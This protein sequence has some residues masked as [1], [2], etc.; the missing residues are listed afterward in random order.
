MNTARACEVNGHVLE[1]QALHPKH[2]RHAARIDL[3][4]QEVVVLAPSITAVSGQGVADSGQPA[5]SKTQL[6]A[7]LGEVVVEVLLVL[8]AHPS[9]LA[10]PSRPGLVVGVGGRLK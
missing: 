6:P 2:L 8:Y 10:T 5:E 9:Q 3:V 1:A 7:S 4:S